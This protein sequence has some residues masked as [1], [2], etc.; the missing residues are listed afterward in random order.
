MSMLATNARESIRFI[1]RVVSSED[2]DIGSKLILETPDQVGPNWRK[3][4]TFKVRSPKTHEFPNNKNVTSK[5]SVIKYENEED[6]DDADER[7]NQS[8]EKNLKKQRAELPARYKYL[9]RPCIKKTHADPEDWKLI[10]EDLTT[11]IWCE[12]FGIKCIN[13]SEAESLLFQLKNKSQIGNDTNYTFS[14]LSIEDESR[15]LSS[16]SSNGGKRKRSRARKSNN[17]NANII[18]DINNTG[19]DSQNTHRESYDSIS[20]AP[21]GSGE[22][23]V[24]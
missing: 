22:L 12:S 1:D 4:M 18:N 5:P 14:K 3:C 17:N 9:L 15:P 21:R 11:K 23:W 20:F 7:G 6:D 2:H 10:T 19:G 8:N 24:P 13:V 16:S